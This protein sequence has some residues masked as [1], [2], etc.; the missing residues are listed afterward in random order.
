MKTLISLALALAT[1]APFASG[2]CEGCD[3]YSD[4]L[5]TP[6]FVGVYFD[7]HL[8]PNDGD[9]LGGMLFGL[10]ISLDEDGDCEIINTG[11]LP[12]QTCGMYYACNCI[13]EVNATWT[14]TASN[15]FFITPPFP[16]GAP[17]D[18]MVTLAGRDCVDIFDPDD[19]KWILVPGTAQSVYALDV[20]VDC[21]ESCTV[22][23]AFRV[24]VGIYDLINEPGWA[25]L[26]DDAFGE[27]W[28]P[29]EP[30]RTVLSDDIYCFSCLWEF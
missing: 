5:D 3:A 10:D 23:V 26:F 21:G 20:D 18:A 17:L 24:K 28:Y 27:P 11:G 1:L 25:N 19:G 29:A 16:S 4:L 15:P 7:M 12:A 6:G 8:H 30:N 22:Y 13:R 14:P 2:Q 9:A